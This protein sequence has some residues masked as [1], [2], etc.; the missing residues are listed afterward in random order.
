MRRAKKRKL[1]NFIIPVRKYGAFLRGKGSKPKNTYLDLYGLHLKYS[2]STFATS[3]RVK[4]G[5]G[6]LPFLSMLRTSVPLNET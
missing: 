1:S 5:G 3:G 4:T 2:L 6:E